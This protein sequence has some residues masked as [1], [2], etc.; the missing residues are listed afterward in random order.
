MNG[1]KEEKIVLYFGDSTTQ[2]YPQILKNDT[3]RFA[4]A[5]LAQE[6]PF[7][8]ITAPLALEQLVFLHQTHSNQGLILNDYD[9]IPSHPFVHEGDFLLTHLKNVGVA[10]ATADCLPIIFY[11]TAQEIIAIAHAGWRGSV[12][13]VGI[14]T[15]KQLQ[16]HYGTRLAN[17]KIF[18]GPSAQEC[19]YSVSTEVMEQVTKYPYGSTTLRSCRKKTFFNLPLFNQLQLQSYGVP[20][21]AFITTFS[22]CTI[23]DL[24]FCSYRR[25]PE[26]KARQISL[27]SLTL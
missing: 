17:L 4:T 14:N 23:C 3:K 22:A 24:S 25:N 1:R 13:E 2:F 10:V 21:D 12:T 27:V 6:D 11:D 20:A 7:K 18:F 19:C 8:N 5:T 26:G 15:L 9:A 16:H